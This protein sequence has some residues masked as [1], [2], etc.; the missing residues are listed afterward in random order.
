MGEGSWESGVYDFK[1]LPLTG[2]E[3]KYDEEAGASYS[4]DAV[5]RQLITYDTIGMAKKKAE[6]IKEEDLGGAMWW[7]SS[8]DRDGKQ[9]LIRNVVEVLGA[10]ENKPNCL[11]YPESKYDNLRNGFKG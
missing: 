11:E 9:S 8:A 5:K 7:E 10:M 4:Y 2:A 6:W 3:E 1:S